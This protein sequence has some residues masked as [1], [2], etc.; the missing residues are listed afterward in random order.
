MNQ[1]YQLLQQLIND[2]N[3]ILIASH[4]S[5][6]LDAITS[7]IFLVRTL[8]LKFPEKKVIGFNENPIPQSY[9]FI[10]KENDIIITDLNTLLKETKPDLLIIVDVNS[11][12]RVTQGNVS[13][14]NVLLE[15][16]KTVVI[17]H[18]KTDTTFK[19]DLFFDKYGSASTAE[20]MYEIFIEGME[21]PLADNIPNVLMLG[22][23]DDTNRFLYENNKHRNTFRITSELI[24]KGANIESLTSNYQNYT[25][26][27][28]QVITE[29]LNN[30][31]QES[32]FNFSYLTDDYIQTIKNKIAYEQFSPAYHFVL[33]NFI[34][35]TFPNKW[36][37]VLVPDLKVPGLY[38][39]SM[40]SI[41][42]FIDTTKFTVELGGGG[43]T[44]ASGARIK[45]SSYK[46]AL[47]K[48]LEVIRNNVNK[49][50][51]RAQ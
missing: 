28:M 16:T 40:R 45:A 38:R 50:R 36:G 27:Q 44:L 31:K 43:H 49:A 1:K 10:L 15:N 12:E 17:D 14:T 5:P 7:T 39:L 2:S 46:E 6:D 37:F 29:L 30:F 23:L 18:H 47:E 26:D 22:I 11:L 19:P 48:V 21:Y 4:I 33:E 35:S 13:E 25:I 3:T 9:R 20:A 8:R 32:N 41:N 34:R 42:G 24:D 51:I